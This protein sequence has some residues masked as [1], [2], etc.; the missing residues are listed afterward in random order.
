MNQVLDVYD[1]EL[2][3]DG[4]VY[5]G[6]G[7]K[8]EKKEY[9]F[10]PNQRQV[11]VMDISKLTNMLARKRLT[12]E[13]GKFMLGKDRDDLGQW[14][15]KQ[16]VM[17]REYMA[18]CQYRLDCQDAVDDLHSKLAIDEFIKDAYGAP[19]VPGSSL[20]GMLRT[21][22]LAYRIQQHPEQ[23]KKVRDDFA[24]N[25]CRSRPR[26]RSIGKR[27][28]ARVESISFRS[29]GQR[30]GTRPD[31]AIND[32]MAGVIISDSLPLSVR[33]L[34]LCRVTELHVDGTER[35]RNVLREALKP[36]TRVQFRL[37]IDAT[38]CDIT[39]E[40]LMAAVDSFGT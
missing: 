10:I 36:G 35:K 14:L 26:N 9:A 19:Y 21:I 31:D 5:I 24:Q 7:N 32:I 11:C 37:T 6:C 30:P 1:V 12:G 4:P 22:L 2:I 39:G 25:I 27:E 23:Y 3:A 13:Y 20:K 33:D 17:P 38:I 34:T 29:N 15:R 8:I 18:C 16:G 40:E 28:A